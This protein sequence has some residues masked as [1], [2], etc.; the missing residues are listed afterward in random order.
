MTFSE[1]TFPCPLA[2]PV[3][4]GARGGLRRKGRVPLKG[5]DFEKAL[6]P[7]RAAR[8]FQWS[9]AQI[10]TF[11]EKTSPCPPGETKINLADFG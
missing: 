9:E 1:K 5:V 7:R 8:T 4:G 6:I 3:P 11:S 2:A 10:V